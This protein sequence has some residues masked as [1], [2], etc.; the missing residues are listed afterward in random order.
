MRTRW[1]AL[2]AATATI[3]VATAC[4]GD[5]GSGGDGASGNEPGYYLSLGD[6]LTVGV[7]PDDNGTLQE[8]RD[9][10]TDVL[11]RNLYDTDSTLQHERMGCGGE[12]TTSF[13]RG[14]NGQCEDEYG[15]ASQMEAAEDFLDEHGDRV[16]LV[17]LTIGGNNFTGC[18]DDLDI[19]EGDGPTVDVD[20]V[21]DGLERIGTELPEI[22]ERL[23]AAAGEDT[24]IV[25]MTYYNPFLAALLLEDEEEAEEG[26]GDEESPEGKATDEEL[27]EGDGEVEGELPGDEDV[28]EYATGV[29]EEMNESMRETYAADGIDVADVADLF[30][31]S[32]FDVPENSETGMPANVQA[33]CDWT[34]MCDTAVGPDIHTNKAGAQEIAGA[35][36][37]QLR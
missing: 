14:G 6:S 26:S 2:T 3:L 16:E 27:P 7:Q 18:V 24:R 1:A 28:V 15:G 21:E 5:D 32:D 25:A 10:Y 19:E 36:E 34:W 23:S 4:G 11:Y 17:T 9:G 20:C 31:S 22:T 8:T 37:D 30:D 35:F 13:L 33:I 29:L 12:D